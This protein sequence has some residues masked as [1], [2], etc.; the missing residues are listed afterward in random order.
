MPHS[1]GSQGCCATIAACSP[2]TS[3]TGHGH[4]QLLHEGASVFGGQAN[5]LQGIENVFSIYEPDIMAVPHT[6]LS[7]TIGDDLSQI[8]Q[9]ALAEGKV[10][11]GK[12][13]VGANTPSYVG[14][15]ITGFSTMVKSMVSAIAE[16]TGPRRTRPS[17]SSPAS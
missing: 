15:H 16:S 9:K 8:A 7:E 13:I 3:R 4:D 12:I 1:H 17:T 6:C 14:S 2:G 5:L 11:K 10:P